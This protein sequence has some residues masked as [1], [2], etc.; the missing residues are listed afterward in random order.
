MKKNGATSWPTT[1]LL[2]PRE[3]YRVAFG[4]RNSQHAAY[5]L[6]QLLDDTRSI[7][8]LAE[9]C[10]EVLEIKTIRRQGRQ[11]RSRKRKMRRR[12]LSKVGRHGQS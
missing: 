2:L 12:K 6:E 10:G 5:H 3:P 4:G 11:M 8:A 1:Q 9:M 7:G